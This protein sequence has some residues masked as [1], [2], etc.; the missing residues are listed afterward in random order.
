[1][2][3]S[4]IDSIIKSIEKIIIDAITLLSQFGNLFLIKL[5]L[6]IIALIS[7]TKNQIKKANI[8]GIRNSLPYTREIIIAKAEMKKKATFEMFIVFL[9]V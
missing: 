3:D 1:M 6:H 8:S 7:L 2:L 4:N 9:K 5:T